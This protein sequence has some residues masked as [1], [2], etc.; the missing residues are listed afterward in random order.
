MLD[1]KSVLRRAQ[2]VA[3][4]FCFFFQV[5]I[6]GHHS[7]MRD[8]SMKFKFWVGH[9]VFGCPPFNGGDSSK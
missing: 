7:S 2:R 5:N 4:V 1:R 6:H 3:F 9:G 8:L